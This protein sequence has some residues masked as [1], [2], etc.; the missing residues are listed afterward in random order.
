[1]DS[2]GEKMLTRDFRPQS[3]IAQTL[4]DAELII[5]E[6][7]RRGLHLPLTTI[8]GRTAAHGDRARGPGPRQRRSHRGD[9]AAACLTG[10][11]R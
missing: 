10:V 2:K 1:M 11:L 4:K 6:A 5:E 3:H 9:P 7:G 8:S